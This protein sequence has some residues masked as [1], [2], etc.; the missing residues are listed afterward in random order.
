MRDVSSIYQISKD[1]LLVKLRTDCKNKYYF[2][3]M[4]TGGR[5]IEMESQ[6]RDILSTATDSIMME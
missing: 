2:T 6:L 4:D 5:I 3:M 1:K